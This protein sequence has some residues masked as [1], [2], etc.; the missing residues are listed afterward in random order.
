MFILLEYNRKYQIQVYC[1]PQLGKR[2]LQSTISKK[3]TYGN[4]L[5]LRD[6]IAYA[7]GE[8]DL[9]EIGEIIGVST[10]KLIPLVDTLLE[11]DLLRI[12]EE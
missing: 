8:T 7:D 1:E 4:V 6:L 9:I 12:V 2:G 10:M 11:Q 5:T 3:G